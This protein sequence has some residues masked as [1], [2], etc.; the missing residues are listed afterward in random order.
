MVP[1]QFTALHV[2][3]PSQSPFLECSP[4]SSLLLESQV[5]TDG[6]LPGEVWRELTRLIP[7]WHE[8][9]VSLIWPPGSA[10]LFNLCFVSGSM[11]TSLKARSRSHASSESGAEGSALYRL[12]MQ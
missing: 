2:S 1:E 9:P 10:S 5:R 11:A 7:T 3:T 4:V 8:L 12:C 6:V